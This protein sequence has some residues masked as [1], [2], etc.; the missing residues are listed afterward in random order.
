MMQ[1][2]T[3]TV[4]L[5]VSLSMLVA[6]KVSQTFFKFVYNNGMC[7]PYHYLSPDKLAGMFSKLVDPSKNQATP[8]DVVC[9][10]YCT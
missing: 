6:S 1:F 4:S 3:F 8:F 10:P 7:Y 2:I 5:H 9:L